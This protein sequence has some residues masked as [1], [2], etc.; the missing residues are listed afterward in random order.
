MRYYRLTI[1]RCKLCVIECNGR[2]IDGGKLE[3]GTK[4][5][6]TVRLPDSNRGG[7]NANR[8]STLPLLE[9]GY[10]RSWDN[11]SGTVYVYIVL[12]ICIQCFNHRCLFSLS[13]LNYRCDGF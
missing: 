12:R 1:K 9:R 3:C 10:H 13:T 6:D 11:V 4:E 5:W 2:V 8:T 7:S